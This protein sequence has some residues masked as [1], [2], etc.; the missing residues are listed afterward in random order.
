M[1]R[2]EAYEL[3]KE[4]VGNKNLIKHML[5]CEACMKE[6]AGKF[7]EDADK[8]GMAGLLHD[9]DY[10]ETEKD[11]ARHGYVTL[12]I[13]KEKGLDGDI[14]DAILAHPGH[15]SREKLIE[16]AL[17]AIDPLTGLIVASALMHPE[18]K[19]SKIDTEFVMRRFKERRFAAGANRDQISSI[20]ES[21][22]EVEDF[23]TLC[24]KAMTDI[25]EEIGL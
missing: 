7:G 25:S 21:G 3:V 22:I 19:I 1:N 11:P 24:L 15:K 8:W 16:K 4:R 20:T 6:L 14:L 13:L 17:Y 18:R 12:D 9:L 5:A 10:P 23:I 2:N